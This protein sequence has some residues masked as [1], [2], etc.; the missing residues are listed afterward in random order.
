MKGNFQAD[1]YIKFLV[2]FAV[3]V[4]INIAGL[5]LFFRLD[6]TANK[7]YSLSKASQEAVA[8]LSEPLTINVFFTENLPAP[9]NSTQRYLKDLL[10]EYAI[11]ANKNFNYRFFD[12][13][14]QEEG[15]TDK[16]IENR[17]LAENYGIYPVEIR[18]LEKD[19]VKFKK[20]Y[21]GLVM[22]HGDLIEQIPAIT[23]TD[24]LEYKLTT[25]IQKLTNKIS[26]L[27]S[28]KEKVNVQLIMSSSLNQVAPFMGLN[29]LP[30]LPETIK[31]TVAKLNEKNYGKLNY[32]YLDPPPDAN[33]EE[34]STQYQVMSLKWPDIPQNNISAGMGVIGLCMEFNQKKSSVPLLNVIRIP[35]FGTRYELTKPETLEEMINENIETLIGINEDIG[36]L[37]DHGTLEITNPMA[38]MQQQDGIRN[39]QALVSENYTLKQISLSNETIPE[40]LNCLIIAQPTESFSD[41]DLYQID[42]ALMR[43]TNLAIFTDA[44]KEIPQPPQQQFSFNMGPSY[45]PLAT[46]LEKLLKHYGVE[47]KTSYV[48]DKNCFKQT[49]NTRAGGM[50]ERPIY[51]AP[52]IQNENI[53]H[54]FD[55]LKNIK[56]L[57]TINNSPVTVDEEVLKKGNLKAHRLF[58]SSKESWEMTGKINLNP[59]FIQP[60]EKE[61]SFKSFPLG[62]MI[63]GQ[64]QSY[65]TGKEIPQKE[66]KESEKTDDESNMIETDASEADSKKS[67]KQ[68]VDLSKIESKPEFIQ[69]G[70]PAKICII[71]SSALLKDNMIDADG[72]SPNAAF[73]L[74]VIDMLNHR[75][76]I[77]VMRSKTQAYNPLKE[78][79][80]MVKNAI[81]IFNIA[82]LPALVVV[83]GLF[84]LWARNR[85]RKR[86]QM[87]FQ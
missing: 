84:T 1:A 46:G 82:G 86:I 31:Q 70:K 58:A 15:V 28:L 35:I 11:Y 81:K 59:M 18:V 51:F 23:T 47:V 68:D 8:N 55:F 17:K 61:D 24:G 22:I 67:K 66:Q 39:F 16:A 52:I 49:M 40:S 4:L 79:D 72:A 20:A 9:H 30:Q 74:N 5:T 78:T 37:A 62:Y 69:T 2:Y 27:A 25:N 65:F 43:G 64:F 34:I 48:M 80:V 10:E 41:Y 71:G 85:R 21:M 50:G 57:V 3:I 19:E 7:I 75:E 33:L 6:L 76:N 53:N 60:P 54:E 42:Q 36:Y 77:A 83:F 26:K 13:S 32:Q 87:M 44:F 12:V 14:P 38:G 45:Q 63:E 29:D 73:V 56:G